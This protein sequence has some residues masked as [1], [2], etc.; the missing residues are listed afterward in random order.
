[1]APE[2]TALQDPGTKQRLQALCKE[3]G[4]PLA[5]VRREGDVLVLVPE[6]LAE[7]PSAD[8]L[9]ALSD[10]IQDLGARYVAFS[11]DANP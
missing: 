9:Q 1:M 3:A 7:L 8:R 6:T 10:R 11:V 2:S 4:F 5:Q